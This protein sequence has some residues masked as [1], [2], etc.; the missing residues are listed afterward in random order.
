MKISYLKLK[1][2]LL[3]ALGGLMGVG[4]T[5]CEYGTPEGTYHVKG[6]VTNSKG[7][8][9]AGIGV[10]Q[11]NTTVDG[12][13][14]PDLRF[15]DTTGADG[16]YDVGFFAMPGDRV[17]VDFVD[18]DGQENGFYG[19]TVVAVS[20][21]R[22]DFQGGDGEWNYGTADIELDVTLTEKTIK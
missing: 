13:V 1:S 20:A 10:G 18:L 5:Y 9:V 4:C 17:N 15:Q 21:S 2:W 3:V 7:A 22:E 11:V 8:P 14:M 6:T 16:R 19:D 12:I